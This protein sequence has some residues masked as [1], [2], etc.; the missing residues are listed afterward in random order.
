MKKEKNKYLDLFLSFLKIGAF[1]FGGGYAMIALL[2]NEFVSKKGWI[3]KDEFLDI[4]AIAESTPGPIAI[5]SATYI[6][7]KVG[8]VLGSTL[9]TLGVVLPSFAII[10]AI[11][12]FFDAFLGFKV[13]KSAFKGIQ[14]CVIYLILSAGIKMFKGL[15]KDVFT[16]TVFAAALIAFVLLSLFSVSFSSIAFILL[17]GAAGIV[18]FLLCGKKKE[19]KK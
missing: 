17:C 5:N 14:A 2:E 3:D 8:G 10:Y 11:S 19:E 6:G 15:K 4:V 16:V 18:F 7:Y 1:T 12:L 13:V 9:A